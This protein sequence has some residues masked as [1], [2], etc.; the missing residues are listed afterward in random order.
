[1]RLLNTLRI[2]F[3][4]ALAGGSATLAQAAAQDNVAGS[5]HFAGAA[6]VAALRE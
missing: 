2:G 5:W 6:R 1:M 4:A 3:C